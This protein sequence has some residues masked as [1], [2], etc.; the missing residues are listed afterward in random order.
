MFRPSAV[1]RALLGLVLAAVFLV[2]PAPPAHAACAPVVE[3]AG[4]IDCDG[5]ADWA[6]GIP[7]SSSDRGAVEWRLGED[8][9]GTITVA[10]LGLGTS[11]PGERFGASVVIDDTNDD[12]YA[13]LIIGAPGYQGHGAVYIAY[14]S[15]DGIVTAGAKRI[16]LPVIAAS[17]NPK[18]G[19]SVGLVKHSGAV[20][21]LLVGAPGW[22]KNADSE[23]DMI[24]DVGAVFGARL[25]T[26]GTPSLWQ[27]YGQGSAAEDEAGDRY[28]SPLFVRGKTFIAG[29]P[30]EDVG[31]ATNTG[32][33]TV[34][35]VQWATDHWYTLW[36]RSF[37]QNSDLV[38]GSNAGADHFAAAVTIGSNGPS[39]DYIVG[40]PDKNIGA[41]TN[42]GAVI[43]FYLDASGAIISATR[44][45]QDSTGIPG[46]NE[47][48][49][50]F[51]AAVASGYD[52]WQDEPLLFVGAPGEDVGSR[53]S[54][55]TVTLL[56]GTTVSGV[57]LEQ[58]DELGGAAEAGDKVGATLALLP[59]DQEE[60]SVDGIVVGAP[61][62]NVGSIIDAGYVMVDHSVQSFNVAGYPA[63][64]GSI[65]YLKFGSVLGFPR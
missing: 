13:D 23:D 54:A 53:N 34:T 62:E 27:Q 37:H 18:F 4:D 31:T 3:V 2:I 7:T 35:R 46:T 59:D 43:R 5:R 41:D 14:G 19:E 33:V 57:V 55:G 56:R 47:D 24:T 52:W 8:D 51:G 6:V 63:L 39:Y 11:A 22:D 42:T 25:S 9:F 17:V 28:G 15:G 30:Y 45:H 50:R 65:A 48:D 1:S 32:Q 58:G 61:G 20:Q 16:D 44:Y 10:S 26:T 21:L 60:D 49:D 36:T 64:G 12:H 38:P 40:V 29:A